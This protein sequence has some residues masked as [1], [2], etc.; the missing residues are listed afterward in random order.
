[1]KRTCNSARVERSARC[2][3]ERGAFET[4][5]LCDGENI[6]TISR[7]GIPVG[8]VERIAIAVLN[9]SAALRIVT[10]D[11]PDESAD[12]IGV[13]DG[14]KVLLQGRLSTAS[15]PVEFYEA[16]KRSASCSTGRGGDDSPP[17]MKG[18][19]A[20]VAMGI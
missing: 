2:H 11:V 9:E 1:M 14:S 20:L 15:S 18:L 7:L 10:H 5:E 17:T 8:V 4:H 12:V 6:G 3:N 19:P 16:Q 13:L